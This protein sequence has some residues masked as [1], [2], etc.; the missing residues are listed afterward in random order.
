MKWKNAWKQR[1][2]TWTFFFFFRLLDIDMVWDHLT[3]ITV[4][5]V[6]WL[7]GSYYWWF[8]KHMAHGQKLARKGVQYGLL[9]EF[10]MWNIAKAVHVLCFS[11]FVKLCFSKYEYYVLYILVQRSILINCCFFFFF[12]G[13]TSSL[14]GENMPYIWINPRK[15]VCVQALNI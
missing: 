5:I 7:P 8:E 1:W 4:I 15:C 9:D 6:V 3:L 14:W 13:L 10:W 12:C 2:K 11:C